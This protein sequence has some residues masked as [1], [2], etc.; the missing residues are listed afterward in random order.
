[1]PVRPIDPKEIQVLL[2]ALDAQ[3]EER[4]VYAPER[5]PNRVTFAPA[6]LAKMAALL[7]VNDHE[8]AHKGFMAQH[9]QDI[10][11]MMEKSSNIA[12][13]KVAV[14]A[15]RVQ[16]QEKG[17]KKPT[18]AQ[19]KE[20]FVGLMNA[21]MK[22][23]GIAAYFDG[24]SG[25][26]DVDAKE[27]QAIT[28]HAANQLAQAVA[29][30]KTPQGKPL[31]SYMAGMKSTFHI[32]G[33]RDISIVDGAQILGCKTGSG[34]LS[35][36]EPKRGVIPKISD[37]TP[38]QS[39]S[40]SCVLKDNSA[41]T[42]HVPSPN[43][44]EDGRKNPEAANSKTYTS[45]RQMIEKARYAAMRVAAGAAMGNT[46]CIKE[47]SSEAVSAKVQELVTLSPQEIE[48]ET[49]VCLAASVK[50]PTVKSRS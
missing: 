20:H 37:N 19:A 18:P 34:G 26:P 21:K 11:A 9:A 25:L 30:A 13:D 36:V 42:V 41:V 16:L 3:G 32:D 2:S 45:N 39:M 35:A 17:I 23:L 6:S 48:R 22:T 12:T 8:A 44:I 43:P 46:Q 50:K 33:A 1:M 31:L 38:F 29:H 14:A 15:G 5:N 10:T 40:M 47:L 7:V 27:K 28:P 24:A 4:A 49:Q